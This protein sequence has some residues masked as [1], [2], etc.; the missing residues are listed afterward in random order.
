MFLPRNYV[1]SIYG[2]YKLTVIICFRSCT[3][4]DFPGLVLWRQGAGLYV[5][6]TLHE[7]QFLHRMIKI[8]CEVHNYLIRTFYYQT[9]LITF[10]VKYD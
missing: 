1:I 8:L 6:I 10:V 5:K 2:L 7:L 9:F 4:F 3:H